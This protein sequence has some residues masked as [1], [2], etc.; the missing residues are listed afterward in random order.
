MNK[1]IEEEILM[2]EQ[3]ITEEMMYLKYPL[4]FMIGFFLLNTLFLPV[5]LSTILFIMHISLQAWVFPLSVTLSGI[6]TYIIIYLK[7]I[8][9]KQ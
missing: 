3:N 9:K 1:K 5:L 6:F 7:K 2:N 4:P 8:T